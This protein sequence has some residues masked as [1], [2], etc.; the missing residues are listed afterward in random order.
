MVL[1]SEDGIQP[2]TG[3]YMEFESPI[4]EYFQRVINILKNE[5]K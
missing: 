3:E 5:L 2:T 1:T 4:P